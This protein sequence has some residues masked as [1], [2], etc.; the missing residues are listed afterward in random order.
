[1]STILMF[2]QFVKQTDFKEH[3]LEVLVNC[4]CSAF[5]DLKNNNYKLSKI[6]MT[7]KAGELWTLYQFSN[8]DDE[9]KYIVLRFIYSSQWRLKINHIVFGPFDGVIET[10]L[11]SN[12]DFK[13]FI[14]LFCEESHNNDKFRKQINILKELK[15]KDLKQICKDT[16]LKLSGSKAELVYRIC[17]NTFR[18]KDLLN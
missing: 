3:F 14:D 10:A 16:N 17:E 8:S 12:D 2:P 9:K 1:M 18:F 4:Y 11:T 5:E 6:L 15:I 13:H 7:K